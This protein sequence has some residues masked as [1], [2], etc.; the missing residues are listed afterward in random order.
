MMSGGSEVSFGGTEGASSPVSER[1]ESATFGVHASRVATKI[2]VT[3]RGV[4]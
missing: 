4:L 3:V 2:T 1:P